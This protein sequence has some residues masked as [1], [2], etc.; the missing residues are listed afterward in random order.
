MLFLLVEFSDLGVTLRLVVWR[1]VEGSIWLISPCLIVHRKE[2][3]A[4]L[5]MPLV[6]WQIHVALLL[7]H[8]SECNRCSVRAYDFAAELVLG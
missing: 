8:T 3:S 5:W 4:I 6:H 7:P 1:Q 2:T